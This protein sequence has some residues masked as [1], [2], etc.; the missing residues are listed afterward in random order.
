MVQQTPEQGF[1]AGLVIQRPGRRN[2]CEEYNN[3]STKKRLGMER[4]RSPQG[5]FAGK[6]QHDWSSRQIDLQ[7]FFNK[8]C[9]RTINTNF[10]IFRHSLENYKR[11]SGLYPST[12]S[13][14][15]WPG[16]F[17]VQKNN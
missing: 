4:S 11:A 16:C 7:K 15:P 6:Y 14:W 5:E 8:S 17:F 2:Q 1:G 13:P 9:C 10:A 3:S 12:L